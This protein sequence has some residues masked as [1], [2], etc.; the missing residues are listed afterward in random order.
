ME[1]IN[2]HKTG[3]KFPLKPFITF[4]ACVFICLL[5]IGFAAFYESDFG[6]V[7][8]E[9]AYFIPETPLAANGLPVRIA[10]KLYR[11]RE[12]SI[13]NPA[14]AVLLMHGYQND[15]E[16]SAAFGIE[17]ARRG[18]V[19]LSIDLYGHGDTSPG[20]RGRGWGRYRL[21]D[22]ERPL[23]GPGRFLVMMTFSVLDF[24]RQEISV[25]VADSSMG[26]KSAYKYLAS[27]SF[28]DAG[29]MGISGHSMGTWAAWSVAAAFPEHRAIVHQCGETIPPDFYEAD[30]IKFNNV[31]LL[32]ALYEEFDMFR[33]FQPNV[34]GLERT[35]RRYR[36]FMGQNAP[37]EWN[38]TYGSFF[39]GSAR[40]MELIQTNHRLTTHDSRALSAAMNWFTS[41]LA[42]QTDLAADDHVYMIKEKLVLLAMLA[43]LASMLPLFL[44]LCRLKYF[45]SLL[46]PLSGDF[47]M[48]PPKSRRLTLLTTILVSGL[49]FPFLTQLG[50]GLI[51]FPEEVFRMTVGNGFIT[52]LTFLMLVSLVILVFW[53]KRGDGRRMEWRLSDLGLG[54]KQERNLP[55]TL[56]MNR[57]GRLI[58]RAV[59]M[60]F[61]LTGM[62]Y[63]LVCVSVGIFGLDL[64]FI[65]PFF[66]PFSPLRLSQ[67]LVYL[68]FYAAFFTVN[69][70]V[71]LYGQLR[72]PEYTYPVCTQFVW[73]LYSVLVMLGGVFLIALI[74]YIPFVM[75]I[76]PGI[77]IFVAPLFGG[78][79][80]SIM[81]VLIP[82]FTVFFFISTWLFRKSGTVYTGSF[83]LAILAAWVISGGSAVF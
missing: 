80:M 45:S 35:A 65:W 5:S 73:W 74:H 52:W 4:S 68:P 13:S 37:V 79:F 81:I 19:A 60:A 11:P 26:G 62:M 69:A 78:P 10:Y 51:P 77:D 14:P 67:F 25:G 50:H 23:A 27:L 53:Y 38:R 36:D 59:L 9:T 3:K 83:V 6:S 32:Q 41:A 72:L 30:K 75:G 2:R 39:D 44:I 71:K 33:D 34:P 1:T 22:L 57:P 7:S 76:G 63:I 49:T 61:M 20:M 42:V 46:Q 31:L 70:G 58:P 64:R 54:N 8:V 28:V 66:R 55:I 16:T 47:K 40:R 15:R 24:F 56:P 43:A 48:L 82:Q 12:V 29:R 21:N 17:L 18:I